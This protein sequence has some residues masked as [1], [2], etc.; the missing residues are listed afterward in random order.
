[1]CADRLTVLVYLHIC[2]PCYETKYKRSCSDRPESWATSISQW[3]S[4][5]LSFLGSIPLFFFTHPSHAPTIGVP[6]KVQWSLSLS[7]FFFLVNIHHLLFLWFLSV[8]APEASMKSVTT[9]LA[10]PSF[11]THLLTDLITRSSLRS[12]ACRWS[13]VKTGRSGSW[14]KDSL[15]TSLRRYS[16]CIN[17]CSLSNVERLILKKNQYHKNHQTKIYSSDMTSTWQILCWFA[18]MCQCVQFV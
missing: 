5:F 10:S 18:E 4:V 7:F 2:F 11:F 14:S 16:G 15:I 12:R 9:T 17:S 3:S 6:H 1:M 8:A 13:S